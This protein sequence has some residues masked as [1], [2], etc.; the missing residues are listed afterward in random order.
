MR[1]SRV[2]TTPSATP[3][4]GSTSQY[5]R[6]TPKPIRS[7][8]CQSVPS[9]T[10]QVSRRPSIDLSAPRY[11]MPDRE[12][13][14]MLRS[15]QFAKFQCNVTL[16]LGSSYSSTSYCPVLPELDKRKYYYF[17]NVLEFFPY[18]SNINPFKLIF[19]N[20]NATIHYA[21]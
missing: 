12:S 11:M 4:P 15:R 14:L 9:S 6:N 5:P 3:R 8:V 20:A 19:N 7:D 10:L 16:V 1:G 18:L 2:T 17:K 13:G 21:L